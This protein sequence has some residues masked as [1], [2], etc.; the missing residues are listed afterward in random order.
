MNSGSSI[1]SKIANQLLENRRA[2]NR[3]RL[4]TNE[5]NKSVRL[6]KG[7]TKT[8]LKSAMD[9]A[10][11]AVEI[12]NKPRTTFRS[13]GFISMMVVAW[14]RLFH[15]Y[16]NVTIGDRYY[17]KKTSSNRYEKIEGE[18]KAWEL[19]TCIAKYGKLGEPV[20]KNLEFFIK[21]RN[22]IEHRHIDKR[23]ID[24]LIFGECQALLYNFENTVVGLFGKE[25]ALN[26]SLVYSLQFAHLRTPQ[27]R[28]SSQAALSKDLQNIVSYIE[29]YRTALPDDI[30]TS[31]EYSIKLL[32]IPKISNTTRSDLAV[33]FVRWDELSKEDREAYDKITT[34]IKDKKV[35]VEAANVGKLKPGDVVDR[36]KEAMPGLGF[37]MHTHTC[38]H[39]LLR[40]RPP[41]NSDDPFDTNTDFCHYDEAHGDYVYQD[42]WLELIINILQSGRTSVQDI[43]SAYRE[44]ENWDIT[45]FPLT[46][47]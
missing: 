6:R 36:V 25:Y 20:R 37:S 10:L 35:I 41:S 8:I 45:D 12:Y 44:K 15:A 2:K 30:F 33:E 11:L 14:N 18:K 1:D 47:G 43:H 13:E 34:I 23:E 21:L 26:E 31:Q 19:S 7:R 39:K 3:A 27:Q 17:H 4:S 46:T 32:Q 22:K 40:I 42:L 24:V 9:A 28:A 5:A 16:F 38:L 29:R